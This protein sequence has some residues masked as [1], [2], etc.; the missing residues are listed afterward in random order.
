MSLHAPER[1]DSSTS[2]LAGQGRLN[3]TV[4]FPSDLN[5]LAASCHELQACGMS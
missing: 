2:T 4:Q 1:G 5:Q 3:K